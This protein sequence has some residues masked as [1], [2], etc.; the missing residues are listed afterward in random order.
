MSDKFNLAG[1]LFG[2]HVGHEINSG[3][4]GL[5][6]KPLLSLVEGLVT[7]AE[8]TVIA[9]ATGDVSA[10]LV[11]KGFPGTPQ[12]AVGYVTTLITTEITNDKSIPSAIS[13]AVVAIIQKLA[14]TVGATL[15]ATF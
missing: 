12:G 14:L 3:V 10:Y 15:P 2:S 5:V 6:D 4:D 13:S 8:P 11:S 9:T 7:A 1:A